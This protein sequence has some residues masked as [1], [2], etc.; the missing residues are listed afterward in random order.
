MKNTKIIKFSGS[1]YAIP[2]GTSFFPGEPIIKI[3]GTA[4][5]VNLITA[6]AMNSF[7]YPI[8]ILTKINRVKIA[9]NG[10]T[11][12][13][14][15]GVRSPG[16]EQIMISLTANYVAGGTT[17]IQ[18]IFYKEHNEFLKKTWVFNLNVNHALIKSFE[19]E[20]D[21]YDFALKEILPICDSM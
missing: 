12:S 10:I 9:S 6:L 18:P 2:D 16:L 8:R 13:T 5:E 7:S 3:T 15:G 11:F 19:K 21:A 14:S 4:L 20:E 1:V 17:A